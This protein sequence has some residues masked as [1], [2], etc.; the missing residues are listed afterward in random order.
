M[1][2]HQFL[3]NSIRHGAEVEPALL[4]RH[5]CVKHHLEEQIA[6]LLAQVL[7]VAVLDRIG[8]FVRFL[9][10]VGSD[11][12]ERLRTVP[13]AAALGIAQ[14]RHEREQFPNGPLGLAHGACGPTHRR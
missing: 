1:A 3:A 13:R 12:G 9:D 11:G 6:E 7:A 8:D 5:A 2:S 14:S 4:L 10:G